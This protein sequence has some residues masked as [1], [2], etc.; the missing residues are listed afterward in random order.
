[1]HKAISKLAIVILCAAAVSASASEAVLMC[2]P[3][4][5][6][7]RDGKVAVEVSSA[8]PTKVQVTVHVERSNFK[9][10]TQP[11]EDLRGDTAKMGG[12][13]CG[14]RGRLVL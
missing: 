1:M 7:T 8:A 13:H 4:R 12:V 6:A 9:M 5:C 2:A 11:D 3:G 10:S 14:M